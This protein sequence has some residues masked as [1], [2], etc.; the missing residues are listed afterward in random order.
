MRIF[1]Q[2]RFVYDSADLVYSISKNISLPEIRVYLYDGIIARPPTPA[3]FELS[4]WVFR[5][6][7]LD[8][9]AIAVILCDQPQ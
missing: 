7:V 6:C 4:F 9:R 3:L 1:G 5:I 2:A 8:N